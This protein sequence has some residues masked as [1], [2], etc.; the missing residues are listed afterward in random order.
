MANDELAGQIVSLNLKL[1]TFHSKGK[2]ERQ[3]RYVWKHEEIQK[4]CF[5]LLEQMWPCDP[6]RLIAVRVSECKNINQV[7]KDKSINDFTKTISDEQRR[8]KQEADL[9]EIREQ[10]LTN[11]SIRPTNSEIDQEQKNE[12]ILKQNPK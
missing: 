1:T 5:R 11:K 10:I 8:L 9:A 12:V 7:R 2:Q 4:V 6:I 3:P